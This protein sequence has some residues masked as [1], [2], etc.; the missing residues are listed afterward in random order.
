MKRTNRESRSMTVSDDCQN[1]TYFCVRWLF[2]ICYRCCFAPVIGNYESFRIVRPFWLNGS[3]CG[4]SNGNIK[5]FTIKRIFTK[6]ISFIIVSL[7][8]SNRNF[9]AFQFCLI[10]NAIK[11]FLTNV[12]APYWV[13]KIMFCFYYLFYFFLTN[14]V[15]NIWKYWCFFLC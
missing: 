7:S 5:S 10:A 14:L 13:I 2:F 3:F 12:N 9:E 6:F 11:L 15:L 1:L 4:R 8:R